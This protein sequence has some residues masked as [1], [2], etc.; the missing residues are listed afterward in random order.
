M[1]NCWIIETTVSSTT[2]SIRWMIE[3][4]KSIA[5]DA[6]ID[7]PP[8]PSNDSD[9]DDDV[10]LPQLQQQQQLQ[11]NQLMQRLIQQQ[12]RQVVLIR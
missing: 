10:E 12:R 8:L 9:D 2:I 11:Q 4:Q 6:G 5:R 3:G 1:T 7:L